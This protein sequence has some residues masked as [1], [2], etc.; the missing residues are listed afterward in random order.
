MSLNPLGVSALDKFSQVHTSRKLLE[1]RVPMES[2]TLIVRST[3][4]GTK[5]KDSYSEIRTDPPT[6]KGQELDKI[7]VLTKYGVSE[8]TYHIKFFPL[9]LIIFRKNLT[10]V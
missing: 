1:G 8:T 7:P 10:C 2:V 5:N 6:R 3:R 4:N 9:V